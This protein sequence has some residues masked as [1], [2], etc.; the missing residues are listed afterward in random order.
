MVLLVYNFRILKDTL[1]CNTFVLE[2][3]SQ[4]K[5]FLSSEQYQVI[6]SGLMSFVPK[7]SGCCME[8]CERALHHLHI[9]EKRIPVGRTTY[10]IDLYVYLWSSALAILTV[11]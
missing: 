7:P 4:E 6:K 3:G 8:T 11:I 2:G 9:I 1:I 5:D 10:S